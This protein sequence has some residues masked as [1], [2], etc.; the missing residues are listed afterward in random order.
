[1]ADTRDESSEE[2]ERDKS[3]G[4]NCESLANATFVQVQDNSGQELDKV[5]QYDKIVFSNNSRSS[6]VT[7]SIKGVGLLTHIRIKLGHL[8]NTWYTK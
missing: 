6:S 8:S 2:G 1:M 5:Q 7:S 4:P 3:S